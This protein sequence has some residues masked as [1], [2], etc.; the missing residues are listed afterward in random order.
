[1]INN[2][3]KVDSNKYFASQAVT[4]EELGNYVLNKVVQFDQYI[5]NSGYLSLLR[6]SYRAYYGYATNDWWHQSSNIVFDGEQGELALMKMNDY[7]SILTNFLSLITNQKLN[8]DPRAINNDTESLS[9]VMIAQS[10]IEDVLKNKKLNSKATEAVEQSLWGAES[11]ILTY[12]DKYKGKLLGV[13]QETQQVYYEGDGVSEVYLGLDVIRE[14]QVKRYDDCEYFI[15]RKWVNKYNLIAIYPDKTSE[16]LAAN[17]ESEMNRMGRFLT[18]MQWSQNQNQDYIPIYHLIHKRTPAVPDGRMALILSG[19]TALL[20][21]PLE[22]EDCMIERIAMADIKDTC[23]GYTLGFDLLGPQM[24]LDSLCSTS[25]SNANAYGV[26]NMLVAKGADLNYMK[27]AGGLNV[28]THNQGMEPK[29]MALIQSPPEVHKLIDMMVAAMGRLSNISATNRGQP[30]SHLKSGS[31][32]ALVASQALQFVNILQQSYVSAMENTMTSWI[33]LYQTNVKEPRLLELSGK[34][35]AQY[36]PSFTGENL[37]LVKRIY[38]DLGNPLSR[39]VSGRLQLA[40]TLLDKGLI[41]TPQEYILATQTGTVEPA[42]NNPI[43]VEMLIKEENDRILKGEEVIAIATDPHLEHVLGH[44]A[45]LQN[46]KNRLDVGIAQRTSDH[47]KSHLDLLRVTDPVLLSMLGQQ[48][49]APAPQQQQGNDQAAQ[50]SAPN[51]PKE[52]KM[53]TMPTNPLT[54]EKYQTTV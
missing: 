44:S 23:L 12:W 35:K 2:E 1:M 53:P 51:E 33:E 34:G 38:I 21:N 14:T 11:F 15:I 45:L 17:G 5:A 36:I 22:T 42:I 40:D 27:L 48:S 4:T 20:D 49:T 19:G 18:P 28:I 30:E 8:F 37:S 9:Q 25:I 31:A 13:D 41:K 46:Y 29:A 3:Y 10:V 7:R 50:I 6:R 39:T 54:K 24:A 43:Q 16:I 32:L 26:Q 47:L 52:A